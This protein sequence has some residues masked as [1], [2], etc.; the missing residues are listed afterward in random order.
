M[1]Q[2]V[3]SIDAVNSASGQQGSAYLVAR[4]EW[5]ER[6]GS[7]IAQAKNWRVAAFLA[8]TGLLVCVFGMV[9][10]SMR[11]KIIPYVVAID[12]TGRVMSQGPASEAA[13]PNDKVIRAQ[14]FDWV[15]RFRMVSSDQVVEG[16]AI[17]RVYAMIGQGSPAS[18][19]VSDM[20]RS[21]SPL[22]RAAKGTV[23]VDIH[24]LYTTSPQ[25]YVVEWTE[26]SMDL[27]G[28]VTGTIN[29]KA[30]LTIALHPPQ[31]EALARVNPLGIYVMDLDVTKIL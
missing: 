31:D 21:A 2:K 30:A 3:T 23:S 14:L 6:Y 29:Y 16:N 8:L 10:M 11:S 15:A 22:E 13:M 17:K 25:T 4:R 20:L 19:K 24:S 9:A 18:V 28:G 7:L 27:Q 1:K 5:D 26:K 12:T